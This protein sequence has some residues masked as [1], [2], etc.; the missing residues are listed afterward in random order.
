MV[1]VD[2]VDVIVIVMDGGMC[3]A[4]GVMVVVVL[5]LVDLASGRGHGRDC[6][7][8]VGGS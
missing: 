1:V 8:T 6:F 7:G 2:G 4:G 5:M 3:G